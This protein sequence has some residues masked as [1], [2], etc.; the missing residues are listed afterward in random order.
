VVCSLGRGLAIIRIILYI[1][2]D[3][4]PDGCLIGLA[5]RQISSLPGL[6]PAA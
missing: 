6:E 5:S 4:F 3:R 1:Y 2:I